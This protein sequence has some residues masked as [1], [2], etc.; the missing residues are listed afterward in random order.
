MLTEYLKR[1]EYDN[2]LVI[3][4]KT[5]FGKSCLCHDI[6]EEVEN[7]SEFDIYILKY[8]DEWKQ[9]EVTQD[10]RPLVFVDNF[11]RQPNQQDLELDW[12][13]KE[14]MDYSKTGKIKLLLAIEL[15]VL[16][17][18]KCQLHEYVCFSSRAV[19]DVS[20]DQWNLSYDEK[21][22][23]FDKFYE[24]QFYKGPKINEDEIKEMLNCE[25]VLGFLVTCHD[26]FNC[27]QNLQSGLEFFKSS[28]VDFCVKVKDLMENSLP[29]FALL[30]TLL[31]SYSASLRE[32][33]TLEYEQVC[34]LL[35][36]DMTEQSDLP[37]QFQKLLRMGL[38]RYCDK[39]YM[40]RCKYAEREALLLF[41]NN[42]EEI[43]LK[44]CHTSFINRYVRPSTYVKKH[45]EICVCLDSNQDSFLVS[46]II[47]NIKALSVQQGDLLHCCLNNPALEDAD[48]F[49]A[50]F[51]KM[52][53][54]LSG[55]EMLDKCRDI[56]YWAC[57][58]GKYEMAKI[59][60]NYLIS[61]ANM[62]PYV[63]NKALEQLR[64]C[65]ISGEKLLYLFGT[66]A[67]GH[68]ASSDTILKFI[69]HSSDIGF[70]PDCFRLFLSK[71]T[72]TYDI[73]CDLLSRSVHVSDTNEDK[74]F[75]MVR[76]ILD[77]HQS[78]KLTS[79]ENIDFILKCI[80]LGVHTNENMLQVL[81]TTFSHCR[82]VTDFLNVFER[83]IETD[84][85]YTLCI[86]LLRTWWELN[87][88]NNNIHNIL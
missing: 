27:L 86:S 73:I 31:F 37:S 12:D 52:Q 8:P 38:I 57:C 22:T 81:K 87:P 6:L 5:Y 10:L 32:D 35:D 4:G 76:I 80:D 69:E 36:I 88:G 47:N 14:M 68:F 3:T 49:R 66:S 65:D 61:S 20:S 34:H 75:G 71:V 11:G 7:D 60:L 40:F 21:R 24:S 26:F 16:E 23:L 44:S 85:G 63:F 74:S 53:K 43:M 56:L 72:V 83:Y 1:L 62:T 58:Y 42:Y 33:C 50:L 70:T 41:A 2:V 9:V 54:I 18:M 29:S 67:C 45:S 79:N 78:F 64:Y 13:I 48:F 25:P 84:I 59:L 77:L 17:R 28:E 39:F 30:V 55:E 19:V 82:G 15:D 51:S 46:K